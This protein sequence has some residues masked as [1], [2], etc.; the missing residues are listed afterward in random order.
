MK[1]SVYQIDLITV[2]TEKDNLNQIVEKTRTTATVFSEI[3]SVSQTEFFSGGRLGLQPSLKVTL[4]DFEYN[5]EPIVKVY[6]SEEK[7]K[8]YSVYRT[9]CVNGTDKIELYLEERGGT[10]DEPSTDDNSSEHSD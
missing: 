10:K 9:Y 3:S 8:L 5:N 6:F 2:V 1:N 7:V 4:Y